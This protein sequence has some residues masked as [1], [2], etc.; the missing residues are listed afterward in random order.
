VRLVVSDTGPVNYL[1]LIGHIEIL[2]GLFEKVLI[3]YV[4]FRELTHPNA[5]DVVRGW[6]QAPPSWLELREPLPETDLDPPL[7]SLDAGER[8]AILLAR[9]LWA[10][11]YC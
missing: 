7:W 10:L 4:V 9:E 5:P 3:P 6:I 2:P 11:A 8:A 1:I